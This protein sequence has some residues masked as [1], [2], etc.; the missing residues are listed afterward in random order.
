MGFMISRY[1][2]LNEPIRVSWFM[3][4]QGFEQRRCSLGVIVVKFETE[5]NACGVNEFTYSFWVDFDN[6]PFFFTYLRVLQGC[7]NS[8]LFSC[9]EI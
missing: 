7:V 1:K 8:L 6:H 9:N 4:C 5:S 2:N 3:S